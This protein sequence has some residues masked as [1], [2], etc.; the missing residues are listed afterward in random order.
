MVSKQWEIPDKRLFEWENP[1]KK[2]EDF[3][4]SHARLPVPSFS[5]GIL[6]PS[7]SSTIDP[8]CFFLPK[9]FNHWLI[10]PVVNL[11]PQTI[12]EIRHILGGI[13]TING[14]FMALDLTH[15]FSLIPI[16]NC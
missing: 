10:S 11:V 13:H 15:V 4:A 6:A 9:E 7:P 14:R 8:M 1:P 5:S 12:P 2:N 3:P 16:E